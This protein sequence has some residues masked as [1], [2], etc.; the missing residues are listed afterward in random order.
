MKALTHPITVV[1]PLYNKGKNIIDTL[2]S[3]IGQHKTPNEVL[4]IDDG[5]TDDGPTLVQNMIE[6]IPRYANVKLVRTKNGGVSKARNR[7]IRLAKYKYIAFIDSDDIWHPHFL[8]EVSMLIEAYPNALAYATRYQQLDYKKGRY[9][10]PKIRGIKCNQHGLMNNYFDVCS[11]GD[12]PFMAS[13][14]CIK[15]DALIELSGFPEN[16]PMGEDQDVW[17]KIALKGNIAYSN[18]VLSYYKVDGENRACVRNIPKHECGFSLRLQKLVK[19]S[20]KSLENAN[21]ILKYTG[22]HLIHIAKQNIAA[23]DYQTAK[24]ILSDTRCRMLPAKFLFLYSKLLIGKMRLSIK[25]KSFS[26]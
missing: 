2:E 5:S 10:D 11:Q 6:T 25:S 4:V 26:M 3:V 8:S 7:G 15:K 18:R 9:V 12:L 16:E 13:S 23:G 1:I 19:H 17:S 21:S 14:I 24:N 20:H 22:T